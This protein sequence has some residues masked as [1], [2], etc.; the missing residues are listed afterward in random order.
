MSEPASPSATNPRRTRKR[1]LRN[2]PPKPSGAPPPSPQQQPSSPSRWPLWLSLALATLA[3]LLGGGAVA[4]TATRP[5]ASEPEA[6]VTVVTQAVT[7]APDATF[8]SAQATQVN[9]IVLDALSTQAL[10]LTD[11]AAIALPGTPGFDEA[12]SAVPTATEAAAVGLAATDTEAQATVVSATPATPLT[13]AALDDNVF[14]ASLTPVVITIEAPNGALT[15]TLQLEAD[16]GAQLLATSNGDCRDATSNQFEA[17]GFAGALRVGLCAQQVAASAEAV[18]VTAV[19]RA[20]ENDALLAQGTLN[21]SVQVES[22][23]LQVTQTQQ[24]G[25]ETLVCPL[26]ATPPNTEQVPFRFTLSSTDAPRETRLY[27]AMLDTSAELAGALW[28]GERDPATGTCDGAPFADLG[29][30]GFVFRTNTPYYGSYVLPRQNR[31]GLLPP[32]RL[33]LLNAQGVQLDG[34]ANASIQP[35]ARVGV[36]TTQLFEDPDFLTSA[37]NATVNA[38]DFMVVRAR[39]GATGAVQ[40]EIILDGQLTQVWMPIGPRQRPNTFVLV[41]NLDD[42]PLFQQ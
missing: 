26:F 18:T 2:V 20:S 40:G 39:D 42:V 36:S 3:L 38:Q 19:L 9:Q 37:P 12:A 33:T 31:N 16:N 6:V 13:V 29:A 17:A 7:I 34:A 24:I 32:L 14:A 22:L 10:Q 11:L 23:A 25:D 35:I 30:D 8:S 21:L 27:R 5:A 15:G 1:S 28:F 41:G 4:L